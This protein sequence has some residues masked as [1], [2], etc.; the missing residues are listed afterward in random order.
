MKCKIEA[1]TCVNPTEDQDKVIKALSNVFDYDK[2][3]I[4]KNYVIISGGCSTLAHLKEFLEKKKIRDTARKI[5]FKGTT[6]NKI[7]FKLSKQAAYA[8]RINLVEE[9]LSLLG[10][11]EVEIKTEDPE[12]AIE[13]LC[14]H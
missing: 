5:F 8:G 3:E 7:R 9:N 6:N 13:W 1:E 12:K 11:I 4:E 2:L 10:E 14:K